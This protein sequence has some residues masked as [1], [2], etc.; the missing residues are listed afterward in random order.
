MNQSLFFF[1]TLVSAVMALLHKM[2][3]MQHQF[4]CNSDVIAPSMGM[5][6]KY[7]T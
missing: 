6:L 1:M 5:N 2:L 4:L 7:K 3:H